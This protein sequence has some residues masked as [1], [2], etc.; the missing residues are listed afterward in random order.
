VNDVVDVINDPLY[1]D[2][3]LIVLDRFK[4]PG[5]RG[6]AAVVIRRHDVTF[7]LD[8]IAG[9]PLETRRVAKR[10]VLTKSESY[11]AVT[12][13]AVDGGPSPAVLAADTSYQ[14]VVPRVVEV[15]L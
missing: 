15:S 4:Q 11:F 2:R 14:D 7:C 9:R 13:P 5:E 12:G 6:F 8:N 1:N 3:R 10:I